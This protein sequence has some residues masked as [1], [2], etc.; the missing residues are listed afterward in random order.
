MIRRYKVDFRDQDLADVKVYSGHVVTVDTY[1]PFVFWVWLMVDTEV[2]GQVWT[3]RFIRD[4]WPVPDDFEQRWLHLFSDT[5]NSN[6][7]IHL[8][9]K[10][11]QP[12]GSVT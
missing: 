5:S 7:A 10:Q 2:E 9:L 6:E 12:F 8:Y 1:E 11:V 3:F 4:N